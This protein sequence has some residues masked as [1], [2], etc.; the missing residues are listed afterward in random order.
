MKL[1]IILSLEYIIMILIVDIIEDLIKW[2]LFDDFD[3]Y[4]W[5]ISIN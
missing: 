2:K 3:D 4:V 1:K 5:K